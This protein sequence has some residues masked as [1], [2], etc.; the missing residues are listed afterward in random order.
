MTE[1]T[2]APTPTPPA[3]PA[4]D[5]RPAVDTAAPVK[6]TAGWRHPAVLLT[7][8]ALALLGWQ[9]AETRAVVLTLK[10]AG[11]TAA[12]ARSS[13]RQSA[14]SLRAMQERIGAI[15]ARVNQIEG[16][17]GAIDSLLQELARTR[18]DRVLAEA[19]HAITI[20]NQHLQ[21]ASD[22]QAA[23]IALQ[24]ADAQLARADRPHW[25]PLRKAL[26][27]DIERLKALPVVDVS[28]IALKIENL[29]AG[30]DKLPLAF[31][32]KP[33]LATPG[34]TA[35]PP[36]GALAALWAD[37][38]R[39][40]GQLVRIERLDRPDPGLL[41]PTQVVF[42]RE[43]LK[44]RLLDARL[45][46]LQRNGRLFQ[47]DIR[48][49]TQW[50]ERYFDGSAGVTRAALDT[51]GTLSVSQLVVELP[52]ITDSLAALKTLKAVPERAAGVVDGR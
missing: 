11:D 24:A 13:G 14:E 47:E 23:L 20:A 49:A 34:A 3:V 26:N 31:E 22:P 39:E 44:L 17:R 42:L 51:L 35:A 25:L 12:E 6:T 2:P 18:D 21:L 38:W 15:D 16:Q 36:Q 29:I 10:A 8:V 7:V 9:W 52:V 40:I 41:A 46:L 33:A 19:E 28:G 37:L 48:Q 1:P 27:R 50:V 5:A 4:P 32:R 30:V 43:N 45:A